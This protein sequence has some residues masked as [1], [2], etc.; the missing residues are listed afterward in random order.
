MGS[1]CGLR[2]YRNASD[3]VD[4]LSDEV[5]NRLDT[6]VARRGRASLIVPGGK[7]PQHLFDG[8]AG[9]YAPWPRVDIM[10]TDERWKPAEPMAWHERLVRQRLLRGRAAQ[11][12]FT[13]LRQ[14]DDPVQARAAAEAAM[15]AIARPFDVAVVGMGVDGNVASHFAGGALLH[16]GELVEA[17]R[18]PG[19]APEERSLRLSL[20]ALQT[21][22]FIALLI[23][24][25]D[26]LAA[27]Q[28]ALGG[29]ATPVRA[30][31]QSRRSG[32]E[33]FCAL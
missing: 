17:A 30:L 3:L 31:L 9:R 5:V 29:E 14:C 25:P 23:T 11:A 27:L 20:A 7:T 26:K 2:M 10:L 6:A 24:G 15:S 21:T 12:R 19:G 8:L 18:R 28:R 4:G 32:L 13:S 1:L 16:A 22:R 33:V